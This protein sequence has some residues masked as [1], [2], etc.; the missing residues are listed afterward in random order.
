[1]GVEPPEARSLPRNRKCGNCRFYEPAPLWRKGW[2]RN[3]RL[4]PPH[5]NHL[6]DAM[7]IDCEGGFRSRIY[8]EP[9][10]EAEV[11]AE[12]PVHHAQP[13]ITP[14][15]I[16]RVSRRSTEQ[17]TLN[18]HTPPAPPPPPPPIPEVEVVN[19]EPVFEPSSELAIEPIPP[20]EPLPPGFGPGKDWRL[21]VRLR[22]P[23]TAQWPL[24]KIQI[25]ARSAVLWAIVGL[26]SVVI[27][28]VLVGNLNKKVNPATYI[29]PYSA[30]V[31]QTVAAQFTAQSRAAQLTAT[32][33]ALAVTPTPT[34]AANKTAVVK[35]T[36]STP[37]NLREGPSLKAK[38][39][40]TINEG[41]K[42]TI[43]DGPQDAE[44]HGWY[45]VQYK[46]ST[47]WAAKDYLEIQS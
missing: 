13:E 15:Q 18:M 31:A 32:A 17:P 47:G 8:W 38:R 40:T 33:A 16:F 36:G 6:V 23:F 9:L 2:C 34:K 26:V 4:Y 19:S 5:A 7:T 24:E 46:D 3:P 29:N 41:E 27:L 30:Q 11:V 25:D 39:I 12:K 10:P 45:K 43:L 22:F 42:V 44:G 1:M 28:I 37:L 21:W 35:G 20:Q 14:T